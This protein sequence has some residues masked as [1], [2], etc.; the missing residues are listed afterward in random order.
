MD[1]TRFSN[2]CKVL[3]EFWLN[4]RDEDEFYDFFDFYDLGMPLAALVFGEYATVTDTGV[5]AI[6]E[7]WDGFC[8]LFDI[9]KYGEF[10]SLDEVLEFVNAGR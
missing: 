9:D 6:E 7:A 5:I 8:A 2:K 10:S 4:W 3:S 1:N